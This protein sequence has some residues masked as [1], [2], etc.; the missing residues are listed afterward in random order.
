MNAVLTPADATDPGPAPHAEAEPGAGRVVVG[1]DAGEASVAALAWAM[2]L[3][4]SRGWTVD[5]VA[6]WPDRSEPFVHEVPGHYCVPRARAVAH[7]RAAVARV[8]GGVG[9]DPGT[10]APPVATYVENAHPVDALLARAADARV[11]VVGAPDAGHHHARRHG[12]VAGTCSRLAACPVV[13]VEPLDPLE[14]TGT[15]GP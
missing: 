6:A 2:R 3:A 1:V 15:V 10:G 13:V 11:L 12:S 5:V 9:G 14:P 4:R 8:T 7:A